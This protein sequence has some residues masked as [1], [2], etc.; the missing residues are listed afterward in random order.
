MKNFATVALFIGAL[1]LGAGITVTLQS[2]AAAR[3]TT[4]EERSQANQ[5][6]SAVEV[7]LEDLIL[8]GKIRAADAPL[9][10]EDV[11]AIRKLIED[12][13]ATPLSTTDVLLRIAALTAK[14]VK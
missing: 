7:L 11:A 3:V 10:R 4:P 5:A 14:W 8:T 13:A 2:C 9:V 12:S 6:L 1:F